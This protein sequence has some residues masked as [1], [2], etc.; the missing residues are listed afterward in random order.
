MQ[1]D[2]EMKDDYFEFPTS[3]LKACSIFLSKYEQAEWLLSHLLYGKQELSGFYV[4]NHCGFFVTPINLH[5]SA[6]T[7][8]HLTTKHT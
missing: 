2:Y 5:F 4:S 8:T 1:S 3:Q 7:K 6:A